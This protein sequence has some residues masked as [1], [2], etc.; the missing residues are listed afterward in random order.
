MK[1]QISAAHT[2]KNSNTA[3]A[4]GS[5]GEAGAAGAVSLVGEA[6]AANAGEV[7]SVGE[8]DAANVANA[9]DEPT[10]IC[11]YGVVPDSIVDGPGLRYSVFVQGCSHGCPG[12]H[13]PESQPRDSGE[14]TTIDAVLNEI[15][16]NGLVHDVTFSG[17]EPFEQAAACATLAR[18]LKTLGYGIW[19]YTG[20]LYEDLERISQ[21]AR[22]A[23]NELPGDSTDGS[24][25]EPTGN[26]VAKSAGEP[27]G[28]SAIKPAGEPTCE[29]TGDSADE[30]S[31][32]VLNEQTGETLLSD[33][34][35][36]ADFLDCIDV[37]VD[38]PFIEAR[39]SLGLQYCGSSNQRLIDISATRAAGHIV[40]WSQDVLT[41]EKPASW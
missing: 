28:D 9:G 4:T 6:G 27:T 36:V 41:F 22:T 1:T 33:P 19:A 7:S 17:G 26:P 25:G 39:K 15:R 21:L 14:T 23:A 32:D 5:V 2:S 16:E 10:T 3:N 12:C 31:G 24:A 30:R 11:L 29:L 38:G 34:Q 40:E 35:A 8:A 20:Y 37:L 18:R 13:N